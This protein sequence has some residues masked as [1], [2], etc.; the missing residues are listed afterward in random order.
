[1]KS[2]D[3]DIADVF[4]R[5][6]KVISVPHGSSSL[7]MP[8]MSAL[9]MCYFEKIIPLAVHCKLSRLNSPRNTLK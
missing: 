2:M 4:I 8:I 6:V 9:F 3:I 7:D 1:M 5:A